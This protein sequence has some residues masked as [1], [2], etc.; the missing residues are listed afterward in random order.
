MRLRDL[1]RMS[2]TG[3][4]RARE[5]VRARYAAAADQA[6]AGARPSCADA[7]PSRMCAEAYD[8]DGTATKG[9]AYGDV[10]I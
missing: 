5:L 3:H 7:D 4:E 1:E 2:T 6:A 8:P 9:R 10:G